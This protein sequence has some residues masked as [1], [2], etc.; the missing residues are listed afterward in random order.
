MTQALCV[1]C[2][3][4]L[5]RCILSFLP[6]Q[7]ANLKNKRLLNWNGGTCSE[8]VIDSV[9][10]RFDASNQGV[11]SSSFKGCL[12]GGSDP[13]FFNGAFSLALCYSRGESEVLNEGEAAKARAV[14]RLEKF[15]EVA[16]D[17][18][19]KTMT[20]SEGSEE[21]GIE[22][23]LAR[24]VSLGCRTADTVKEREMSLAR[25]V[26]LGRRVGFRRN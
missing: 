22:E 18:R 13:V 5:M 7:L 26:L 8:G 6:Y 20:H 14:A 11:P 15:H 16:A 3:Q 25:V 21:V 2:L 9:R 12:L 23:G 1:H 17:L 4:S 24:S 19:R 10:L